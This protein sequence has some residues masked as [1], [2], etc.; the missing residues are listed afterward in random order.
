MT[1]KNEVGYSYIFASAHDAPC[2]NC[3]TQRKQGFVYQDAIPI[4][5]A[6]TQYLTSYTDPDGPEA[7]MRT[8][9]SFEPKHVIPFLKENLNWV[10][11]HGE[12]YLLDDPTEIRDSQLEISLWD[13]I[14]DLPT[15][16]MRMGLYYPA[17][18]HPEIT[19]GKLGGY[20][21]T[22]A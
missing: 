19:E 6:L 3:L 10:V 4:T 9:Q 13:R 20:G 18:L 15:V 12:S 5:T 14:Y 21:Y 16:E 8:L 17:E 7:S 11:T 22:G 1:K 2:A